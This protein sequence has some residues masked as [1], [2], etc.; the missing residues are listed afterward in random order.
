MPFKIMKNMNR[1]LFFIRRSLGA[2]GFCFLFS[3]SLF[4]QEKPKWDVSNPS[5]G[6][7]YHDV[8]FTTSEGTW[9]SLDVSPDGKTIVFDML[10]DIYSM[11]ISGG[12]ATCLRS[13]LAWEVQPRF[14]PDGSKMA[15]CARV[16]RLL[17]ALPSR[18]P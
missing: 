7:P 11:P 2:G 3:L 5:G 16:V 18:L 6:V 15:A 8:E 1:A 13:G 10:G 4:A 9:M 12:T 14:S 17:S